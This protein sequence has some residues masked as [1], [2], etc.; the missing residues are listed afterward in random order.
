MVV[1]SYWILVLWIDLDFGCIKTFEFIFHV[2]FYICIHQ[3]LGVIN[4][5]RLGLGA[6]L[7]PRWTWE[8]HRYQALVLCHTKVDIRA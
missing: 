7:D 3:F 1:I 6:V 5:I 4:Y 8:A 2:F